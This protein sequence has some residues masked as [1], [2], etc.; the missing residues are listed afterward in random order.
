MSYSVKPRYSDAE[1]N[2]W[3]RIRIENRESNASLNEGNH[4]IH[5]HDVW[6]LQRLFYGMENSRPQLKRAQARAWNGRVVDGRHVSRLRNVWD[7]RSLFGEEIQY[8]EEAWPQCARPCF[9][10]QHVQKRPRR[11]EV[12][13]LQRIMNGIC[14]HIGILPDTITICIAGVTIFKTPEV[15]PPAQEIEVHHQNPQPHPNWVPIDVGYLG[16]QLDERWD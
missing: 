5:G 16:P 11:T 8:E 14:I 4:S 2:E 7:L 3:R 9:S 6:N 1:C 12:L 10:L 15:D 13:Q